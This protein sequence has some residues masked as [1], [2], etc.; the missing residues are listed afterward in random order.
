V[1]TYLNAGDFPVA[2]GGLIVGVNASVGRVERDD[3]LSEEF[4]RE[5]TSVVL[6]PGDTVDT[7]VSLL[8]RV[9]VALDEHGNPVPEPVEVPTPKTKRSSAK[10]PLADQSAPT[11]TE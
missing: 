8:T 9:L 11:E 3:P 6:F 2:V 4:D 5:G 10:N 7:D 1:T